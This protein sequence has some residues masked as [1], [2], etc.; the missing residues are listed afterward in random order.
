VCTR[1]PDTPEI[2]AGVW[3]AV[4]ELAPERTGVFW[5]RGMLPIGNMCEILPAA[6]V[7]V[8]PSLHEPLGNVNLEAMAC[9]TAL[10][11]SDVGG[12]PEV[13]DAL[14]ADPAKAE[15]HSQAGR[16]RCISELS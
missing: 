2:A 9:A 4:A 5:G 12:I 1:A 16:Q 11:A 15:H 10:V 14:V 13:V 7:L 8:Y 3:A 6:T